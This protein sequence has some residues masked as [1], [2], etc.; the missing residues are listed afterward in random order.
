MI[1]HFFIELKTILLNEKDNALFNQDYVLFDV[2]CESLKNKKIA[3]FKLNEKD[4]LDVVSI[5]NGEN[6]ETFTKNI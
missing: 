5:Y 6:E 3:E 4:I 2:F 1:L